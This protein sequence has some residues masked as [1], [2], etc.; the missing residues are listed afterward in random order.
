MP[1]V[2]QDGRILD[3]GL[4]DRIPVGSPGAGIDGVLV[5]AAGQQEGNEDHPR[6]FHI[7]S[8]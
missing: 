3:I 1:V 8:H 6:F 2:Q 4:P 7:V 5:P